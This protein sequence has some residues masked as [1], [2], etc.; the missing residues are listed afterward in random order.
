MKTLRLFCLIT[1][2][3]FICSLSLYLSYSLLYQNL[4]DFNNINK[5]DYIF[6]S[7]I[8][9]V[10][11]YISKVYF[12][13]ARFLPTD[14]FNFYLKYFITYLI[15]FFIFNQ[16]FLNFFNQL[17]NSKM[18]YG[19][20]VPRSVVIIDSLLIFFFVVL[21]RKLIVFIVKYKDNYNKF[22]IKRKKELPTI[23]DS[24]KISNVCIYG[25]GSLGNLTLD[26]LY[27]FKKD[28]NIDCF[29]DDNVNLH[30][31]IIKG[32]KILSI[33]DIFKNDDY[34]S[35][36]LY[37]SIKDLDLKKIEIIN[38]KYSKYFE[39]VVYL[40]DKQG[41][42]K[43]N[44]LHDE[45]FNLDISKI[46]PTTNYSNELLN[47][48][49]LFKNKNILITGCAGSIGKELVMQIIKYKSKNLY[50]I[51]KNEHQLFELESYINMLGLKKANNIKFI[52]TNL[53][54]NNFKKFIEIKDIDIIFHAAAYKHVNMAENNIKSVIYNNVM[55]TYNL[56]KFS[57]DNKIKNFVN[58]STDKA[59]NPTS[60]MGLSKRICEMIVS[61]FGKDNNYYSVRFGNV[62][63]SSGSVL[64]IFSRQIK[65]NQKVTITDLEVTRYFMS[66]PEAISLILLSVGL[67][68]NNNIFILDMG[69]PIK[70]FDIAKRL[71]QIYNKNLVKEKKLQND[72]E[73]I[74]TGLKYGEKLHEELSLGSQDKINTEIKKIFKIEDRSNDL[75]INDFINEFNNLITKKTENELKE[76][77]FSKI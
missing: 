27:Q 39:R 64:P 56:C 25:A 53:A 68:K 35:Y 46:I 38:K 5:V 4:I 21:S 71:C 23:I 77:L 72:V 65:N 75:N 8:L 28:V 61:H 50:L 1:L 19:N 62:L 32:I 49:Y 26:F 40:S 43:I 2:D 59:V 36:T 29:F 11:F 22:F 58:V 42:L 44:A 66:I 33:N 12:Y 63:N 54:D 51:D 52:L 15:I 57:T 14:A 6:S 3:I 16:L 47:Y 7:T 20:M 45:T 70:I 60:V 69:N 74:V 13:R 18:F 37:I 73:Y 31:Q 34:K 24:K 30:G 76:F 41:N 55:A 67:K 9:V 48:E 10:I 17:F